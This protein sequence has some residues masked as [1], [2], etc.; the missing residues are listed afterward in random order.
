MEAVVNLH[1]VWSLPLKLTSEQCMK[2]TICCSMHVLT[3]VP[4]HDLALVYMI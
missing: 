2:E 1:K 4:I 3:F